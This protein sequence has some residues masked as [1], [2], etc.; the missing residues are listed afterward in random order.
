MLNIVE[1][2]RDEGIEPKTFESGVTGVHV[3]ANA[4]KYNDDSC[5]ISLNEDNQ[6]W[7]IDFTREIA[8]YGYQIKSSYECDWVSNWTLYISINN[9]NW[10]L[11]DAQSGG[12]PGDKL[13]ILKRIFNTRYAKII[14]NAP[15]CPYN[16]E[17]AFYKVKFYGST[18]PI[19]NSIKSCKTKWKVN[20][21]AMVS[22][23]LSK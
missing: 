10:I 20:A 8:I 1:S 21:L 23:L 22:F 15:G 17:L 5:F 16:K 2:L 13:F 6:F 7:G 9:E 3:S 14:G 12:Y 18:H 11:V 4:I 19:K